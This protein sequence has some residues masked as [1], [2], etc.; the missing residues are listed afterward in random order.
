MTT[1]DQLTVTLPNGWIVLAKLYRG[2]PAA[3]HYA[4]RTQAQRKALQLGKD[5][6]VYYPRYG[7]PFYVAP[8]GV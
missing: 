4:N 5:W 2:E 8:L 1:Y 6:S 3:L 7:G